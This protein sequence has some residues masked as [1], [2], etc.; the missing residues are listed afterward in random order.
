MR[1]LYTD[2][3]NGLGGLR[4]RAMHAGMTGMSWRLL[5]AGMP[6]TDEDWLTGWF[7]EV[8]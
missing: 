3:S 5:Q 6:L 8:N 7:S 4:L 2:E 1:L